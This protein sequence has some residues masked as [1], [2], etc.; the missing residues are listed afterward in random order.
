MEEEG[1]SNFVTWGRAVYF[2]LAVW[3]FLFLCEMLR[4]QVPVKHRI[5]ARHTGI[6]KFEVIKEKTLRS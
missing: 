6:F 1:V 3:G 4:V 5:H 2:H